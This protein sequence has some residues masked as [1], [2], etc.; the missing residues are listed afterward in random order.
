MYNKITNTYEYKDPKSWMILLSGSFA[1]VCFWTSTYPIDLA[2]TKQQTID[3]DKSTFKI[4]TTRFTKFG[5]RGLYSGLLVT[6]PRAILS[7]A[8]IF[9]TYEEVKKALNYMV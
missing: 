1:G 9:F 3:S 7:N 8:F 4:L 2:K 5:F 6:I